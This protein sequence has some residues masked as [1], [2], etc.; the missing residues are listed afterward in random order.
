[1][2]STLTYLGFALLGGVFFFIMGYVVRKYT[3]KMKIK[4]AEDK[5]R[6]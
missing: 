4:R 3:A 5:A 6:P 2:G 1:M